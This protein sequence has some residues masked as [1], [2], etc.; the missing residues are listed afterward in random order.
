MSLRSNRFLDPVSA[1]ARCCRIINPRW[2]GTIRRRAKVAR[3]YLYDLFHHRT[4]GGRK[5][6]KPSEFTVSTSVLLID[7]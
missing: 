2:R 7:Q 3:L 6:F 5:P 4:I 1:W